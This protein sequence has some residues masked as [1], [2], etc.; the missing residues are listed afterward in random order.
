MLSTTGLTAC[1]DNAGSGSTGPMRTV[2][3][4]QD[5]T[6]EVPE[7]PKRIIG[8]SEPTVD[9]LLALGIKPVGVTAGRGQK[10]LPGYLREQGKGLEIVG[11][12]GQPNFEAI[13]A[14]KPD[15]IVVDGTSV[16]NN[17][18][19]MEA[20]R[21]IAPVVFTGYAGGDWKKNLTFVG[22]AVNKQDEAAKVISDYDARAKDLSDKL[23]EYKDK[24]FSIVRWQGNSASLILKELPAGRALNDVGLKRPEKQDRNGQGHSD[25]VSN[26][27]LE[28]I[29]AD[30]MFFGSLGG[31]SV[32]NPD[33][34][35]NSDEEASAQAVSQAEEVPGFTDL[36]AYRDAHIMPIDGSVWTST[37][38][39]IMM[40]KI[41]DD[42]QS[43]LV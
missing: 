41:L 17:P 18:P 10:E 1:G 22:D 13:G 16:N 33:A 26:E 9:G 19:V 38:G 43:W 39:P 12:I 30:Y 32:N 40:N 29:D 31:S 21:A 7:N 34:G 27:N 5:T 2:V 15:L 25:P 28:D 4:A 37:G 36:K 3:D 20:L 42:I 23:G 24:T 14:A 35:G 11:S 6:V 8:L